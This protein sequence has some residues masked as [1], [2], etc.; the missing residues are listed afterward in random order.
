VIEFMYS[1]IIATIASAALVALVVAVAFGES[2]QAS[3][4]TAERIADS[5]AKVVAAAA[6]ADADYFEQ[7]LA[8]DKGGSSRDLS[9]T[10]NRTH[11]EVEKGAHSV[12]RSFQRSVCLLAE[13]TN[14]SSLAAASGSSIVIISSKIPLEKENRVT[15]E[16]LS[17]GSLADHP[18]DS[19]DEP[20]SI[21]AVVVD[22]ER[23][24]G[25]A[26]RHPPVLEPCVRAM[27]ARPYHHAI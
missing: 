18:A 22:V 5:I 1:R 6:G 3:L 12:T 9:I 4:R 20:V 10:I 21:F 14:A 16:V 23:G 8:V 13:G 11:V 19:G 17:E 26:V 25:G 2:E 15:V 27:H 24:A 7:S